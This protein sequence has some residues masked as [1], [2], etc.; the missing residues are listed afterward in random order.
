M[1]LFNQC[2]G[3]CSHGLPLSGGATRNVPLKSSKVENEYVYV[4]GRKRLVKKDGRS[5][6]VTYKGEMIKV[7][8]AKALE[9][10]IAKGT[11]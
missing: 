7:A 5:K 3:T 2:D 6:L 10:K 9:K 1:N 4:L 8:D 11:K